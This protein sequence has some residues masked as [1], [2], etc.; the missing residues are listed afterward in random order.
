VLRR[1]IFTLAIALANVVFFAAALNVNVLGQAISRTTGSDASI[2]PRAPE[3]FVIRVTLRTPADVTLLT[4]GGYDLL[5]ARDG[6]ALFVIGDQATLDS[7]R[8]QGFDA[9]VY[10]TLQPE[11]LSTQQPFDKLGA[12]SDNPLAYFAGYR[13]VIEHYAHMDAIAAAH[14]DL[15]VV[16]DYGDSWRKLTSKPNGHDLEAICITRRRPQDCQLN[17]NTDKP[18]FF[19]MAAIHARELSTSEMAWRWMDYLVE[20]YNVD[21]DVTA[22]LDYNEMWIAPVANPDGRHLVEQGGNA[23]YLQR[24]NLNDS[25]G[26]CGVAPGDPDYGTFQPGVDLNRNAAFKWGV[27]GSTTVTCYQ[28][29]RGT[30]PASEPEEHYLE[31]L[32][33]QLFHDQRG[34]L[35]ADATPITATGAMLTLHS[36]SDLVLLPWGWSQCSFGAQCPPDLRASNDTGLRAFAFRMSYYNGYATGQASELLYA[37]S[38]TTDDWAYGAL[39]IPGFTFEIGPADPGDSCWGFTPPYSCQDSRFW[40]LNRGAFLYAARLARQPYML[41][42][43]PNTI[44]VTVS[45]AVVVAGAPVTLSA[46][47]DDGA[48]GNH[49]HSVGRPAAQA[50]AAAEV[51]VDTPPWAGGAPIGMAAQ[52]SAFDGSQETALAVLDTTHLGAGRHILFVRGRDAGGNWGAVTAQWLFVTGNLDFKRYFPWV[53]R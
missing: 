26:S 51:Y 41:A 35:D 38:G 29:Y 4:A 21:P 45:S 18:R 6:N 33:E 25:A 44:S 27:S 37:A 52:D 42:L 24:K 53:A 43:G 5:E 32:M 17:P 22:L 39:G 16:V 8:A 31:T 10:H 12:S 30:A 11:N 14:P 48:L 40:P 2:Q 20:N 49:P 1:L 28:T 19:L 47:V 9:T 13:T 50:I 23:P 15:A 46:I 3:L 36:F 34:A 7:L